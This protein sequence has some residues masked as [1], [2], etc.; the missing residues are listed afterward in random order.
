MLSLYYENVLDLILLKYTALS[1]KNKHIFTVF[2]TGHFM[3]LCY[4]VSLFQ[5]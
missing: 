1:L 3:T 5:V 4:I 2:Q